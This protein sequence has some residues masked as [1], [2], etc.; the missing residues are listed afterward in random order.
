[1]A[2][3][4]GNIT[5]YDANEATSVS[6]SHNHNKD[7]ND[8]L[9]VGVSLSEAYASSLTTVQYGGQNM[10][11]L[12]E[13][14]NSVSPASLI[15]YKTEP[16]STGAANISIAGAKIIQVFA[17]SLGLVD[18][19]DLIDVTYGRR[20]GDNQAPIVFSNTSQEDSLVFSFTYQGSS[21]NPTLQS[22]SGTTSIGAAT[23]G[24]RSSVAR[25]KIG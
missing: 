15:Y 20:A 14:Q 24:N 22:P 19:S 21:G 23:N 10:E 16:A 3:E 6:F 5:N 18:N 7:G 25:Y 2:I 17:V 1:M 8:V 13:Q 9:I 11:F 4:I 12:F